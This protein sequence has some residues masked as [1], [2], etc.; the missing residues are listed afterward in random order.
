[1]TTQDLQGIADRVAP[2]STVRDPQTFLQFLEEQGQR[3]QAGAP[4]ARIP[5]LAQQE[6]SRSFLDH[7]TNSL[8]SEG[9]LDTI[10]DQGLFGRIGANVLG[11]L[12]SPLGIASTALLAT[13]VG[14][15]LGAGLRAA[16]AG[17]RLAGAGR[18]GQAALTPVLPSARG[19]APSAIA[20]SPGTL[21]RS[22]AAEAGVGAG[23]VAGGG[24]AQELGQTIPGPTRSVPG[25]VALGL[26]GGLVGGGVAARSLGNV[27]DPDFQTAATP[28]IPG[29]VQ[30]DIS[31]LP[32]QQK[33]KELLRLSPEAEEALETRR[34][35]VRSQ[36][37][38]IG[39]SRAKG[40]TDPIARRRAFLSAQTGEL[41]GRRQFEPLASVPGDI[42]ENV[43]SLEDLRITEFGV[44]GGI[45]Q[46]DIQFV[47]DKITE[48]YGRAQTRFEEGDVS[49]AF[50]KFMTG[51]LPTPAE[52]DLLR[53]ILGDETVD[54][55]A[56][57]AR[58][59]GRRAFETAVDFA[60]LPRGLMS[61]FDMSAVMRQGVIG[62]VSHPKAAFYGRDSAFTTALKAIRDPEFALQRQ[63]QHFDDETLRPFLD[64]SLRPQDRLFLH[65]LDATDLTRREE[66]YISRFLSKIPG[67]SASERFFATY[68]NELRVAITKSRAQ[69]LEQQGVRL[70]P[71]FIRRNNQSINAMTGR[72]SLGPLERPRSTSAQSIRDLLTVSFWSPRLLLSRYQTLLQGGRALRDLRA[73]DP[74]VR[75]ISREIARD[76]AI[77]GGGMMTAL[78]AISFLPG[79]SVQLDPRSSDFGKARVGN[80]RI[81]PWAGFQQVGR[82]TTQFITGQRKTVSTGEIAQIERDEVLGRFLRS[83]LAPGVPAIAASDLP[84][85]LILSG[86]TGGGENFIGEAVTGAIVTPGSGFGAI[87]GVG[88]EP[89]PAELNTLVNNM[90]PLLAQD[91]AEALEADGLMAG[92]GTGLSTM[93]GLSAVS[94]N[95]NTRS[96]VVE[97]RR[98]LAQNPRNPFAAR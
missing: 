79:V 18:L 34:H 77:F 75:Q 96:Q 15:P 90:V 61:S 7:L 80:T 17:T 30:R 9:V 29:A 11:E 24:L 33:F 68:L 52:R 16:T 62:T 42:P 5:E 46:D 36:R 47:S 60:G 1:M 83:K 74:A 25:Q 20:R 73:D 54:R 45:G 64:E 8:I 71:E 86:L 44:K 26:G 82:Y 78:T 38:G 35:T 50:V 23:A 63:Q 59:R 81:D 32:T 85:D 58:S 48:V 31:T 43:R 19:L 41:P 94:F 2:G 89:V 13:G 53:P 69:K 6:E 4:V 93:F 65:R 72:G 21:G 67:V 76:L 3:A 87:P 28:D 14:A 55:A 91:I 95:E 51:Q 56:Q 97:D 22:L 12:T 66:I 92:A 40:L 49:H 70:S 84:E 98:A 37:A 88:T 27:I 10:R 57:L 39:E